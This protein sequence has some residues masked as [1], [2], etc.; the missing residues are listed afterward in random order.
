MSRIILVYGFNTSDGGAKTVARL[1][2]YLRRLGYEV[3][4][5]DYG[6]RFLLGALVKGKSDAKGLVDLYQPGDIVIG[7]S[8]GCKL[9]AMAIEMG[10]PVVRTIFIHPALDKDWVPPLKHP[11]QRI[12]VYYSHLD[13]A[14]W[15]AQFSPWKWGGMGTYGPISNDIRFVRHRERQ[16]H[17]AGFIEHPK[18]YIVHVPRV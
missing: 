10:M 4:T 7:H 3:I 12:D 18:K 8:N 17:S 16:R 13:K 5:Y 2:P 9:I 6:Y 14:T 15:W 11:V 1:S